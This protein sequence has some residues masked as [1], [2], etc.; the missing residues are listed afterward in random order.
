MS[1]WAEA[2]AAGSLPTVE[3]LTPAEQLR[4]VRNL[5]AEWDA[6]DGTDLQ[7]LRQLAAALGV[8]AGV[9]VGFAP[10]EPD[11]LP[12]AAEVP[13]HHQRADGVCTICGDAPLFPVGYD[14]PPLPTP[15]AAAS[16]FWA[17]Y[18]AAQQERPRLVRDAQLAAWQLLT[19]AE[20]YVLNEPPALEA[21]R[22]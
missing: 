17:H 14:M 16:V 9:V 10:V 19:T 5:C 6:D 2:R 20:Q 21:S 12:Q 8:A 3:S 4:R 7:A 11:E 22:A 13:C 18:E 15:A 1:R